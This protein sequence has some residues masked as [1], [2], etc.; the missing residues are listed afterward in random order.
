MHARSY[1][2]RYDEVSSTTKAAVLLGPG[3]LDIREL[4]LPEIGEDD[5]LLRVEATGVCGSDIA[6][7]HGHNPFYELPC[8]MGHELVG[9]VERIGA[10]AAERWGVTEGDRIV[11]EEYL[12]CGTCRSCLAGAYQMCKVPRY[13]GKSIHVAPGLF[14]GYADYLYL[15]P[16]SI[17]HRVEGDTPAELVQL[18][19]PIS[20]GLHWV[21]NTAEAKIGSTVVVIGPGPHGLGAVIGAREAGART[22]I[23]VGLERDSARLEV[24]L[25]LGADH[26]LSSDVDDVPDTVAEITG[27][28]MAD[29][30]VNAADSALTIELAFAVAGDRAH[31]AQ[32]GYGGGA[33]DAG[34]RSLAEI[35]VTRRITLR[36]VLGRPAAAVPAALRI[37]E[38][39]RYPLERMCTGT[40]PVEETEKAL[41]AIT[42]DPAAIR[43]IVV[44]G[45]ASG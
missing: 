24:G 39:G 43:S 34:L 11:V 16:Q 3:E 37:I 38:S 40:F 31:I 14:G 18:Y 2:L 25:E 26:V 44:P 41:T 23:L 5:G 35:L 6:A 19:I 10:A 22:V 27:G 9:R 28:Q 12:P 20:N 45:A 21:Q 15:H 1:V 30:I 36:G 17:V 32:V 29:A 33:G 7:Y 42:T 8:V 4:P 13:G